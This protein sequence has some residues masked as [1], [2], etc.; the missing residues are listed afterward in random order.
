MNEGSNRKQ[1][2]KSMPLGV[3]RRVLVHGGSPGLLLWK[4]RH[5]YTYSAQLSTLLECAC[6]TWPEKVE[7]SRQQTQQCFWYS[8]DVLFKRCWWVYLMFDLW[9]S[10]RRRLMECTTQT[11][12]E[13]RAISTRTQQ[14]SQNSAK[15]CSLIVSTHL[16]DAWFL[17]KRQAPPDEMQ[18]VHTVEHLGCSVCCQKSSCHRCCSAVQQWLRTL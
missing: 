18:G 16:P 4:H 12:K 6:T 17:V 9:W 5:T 8:T 13:N 10:N 11:R 7:S 2:E 3:T 1:K 15:C 14:I